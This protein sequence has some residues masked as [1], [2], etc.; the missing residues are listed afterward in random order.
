MTVGAD[1]R[2]RR[3]GCGDSGRTGRWL[4]AAA[5]CGRRVQTGRRAAGAVRGGRPQWDEEVDGSVRIGHVA[6]GGRK[7]TGCLG[8]CPA[9]G[10]ARRAVALG[11]RVEGSGRDLDVS[12]AGERQ[13]MRVEVM[14]RH[15]GQAPGQWA[16]DEPGQ[17]D[18][19]MAVCWRDGSGGRLALL[20]EVGAGLCTWHR[21]RTV[22]S[23]RSGPGWRSVAWVPA[24]ISRGE[25]HEV[26]WAHGGEGE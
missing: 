10:W 21:G 20:G 18:R 5:G 23:G 9:R 1:G 19:W 25:V 15:S 13:R 11:W 7:G 24:Q 16:A 12:W 17:M 14:T 26:P 4:W 3:G 8:R 6:G 22:V 2:W